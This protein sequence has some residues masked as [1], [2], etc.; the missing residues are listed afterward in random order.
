MHLILDLAYES[1]GYI[2]GKYI[3]FQ[4]CYNGRV[5]K[6]FRGRCERGATFVGEYG[7]K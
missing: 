5:R 4:R 1:R 2:R 6:R 7:A 3:L